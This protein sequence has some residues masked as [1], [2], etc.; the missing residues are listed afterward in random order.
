MTI[1]IFKF[2]V[3]VYECELSISNQQVY[4]TSAKPTGRV[5]SLLDEG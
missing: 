2:A 4:L 3:K 5:P 1:L